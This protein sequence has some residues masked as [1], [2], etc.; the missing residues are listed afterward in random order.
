[1]CRTQKPVERFPSHSFSVF[2]LTAKVSNAS[3][4]VFA[5]TRGRMQPMLRLLPARGPGRHC[6]SAMRNPP[7]THRFFPFHVG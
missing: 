7:G 2:I 1:M 3:N 6:H 5:V 4:R